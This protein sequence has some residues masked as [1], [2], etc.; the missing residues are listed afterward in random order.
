MNLKVDPEIIIFVVFLLLVGLLLYFLFFNPR[1]EEP[2]SEILEDS[3]AEIN[4][5][6]EETVSTEL[7]IEVVQEG[8]G[9]EAKNGDTLTVHYSGY[10]EDGTKFD[11]SLDGGQPFVFQIGQGR[12]IQGWEKGLL[13]MKVGE[14]RKITIPPELGYGSSGAGGVIPP[15]ATLIFEVELLGIE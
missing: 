14:K 7:K 10:L 8:E 11:S 4:I 15:N 2:G 1:T 6:D 5:Q 9:R 3:K 13:A 12:V